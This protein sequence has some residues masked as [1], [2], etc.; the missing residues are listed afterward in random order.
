MQNQWSK[1]DSRK[2]PKKSGLSKGKLRLWNKTIDFT[3]T[4]PVQPMGKRISG[5]LI[6]FSDIINKF[7][8]FIEFVSR[9]KFFSIWI[10][11]FFKIILYFA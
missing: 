6:F 2:S 4:Q 8:P 5:I 1:S 3:T 7:I 11:L 9:L 10:I